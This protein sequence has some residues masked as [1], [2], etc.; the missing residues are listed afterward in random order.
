MP[1]MYFP[2]Y[3]KARDG[4][5]LFDGTILEHAHRLGVEIPSECGGLGRCGHCVVRIE[6]GADTLNPKTDLEEGHPLEPEERLACQARVVKPSGNVTVFA[7]EVGKYS[8]VT[9][10]VKTDEVS[11]D[12][13]V[14]RD[15]KHIVHDAGEVLAGY[16]G[17]I[18]GLAVDVGTT[19]LVI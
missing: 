3:R 11:L 1:K 8:I 5:D 7:K 12:P 9:E 17:E 6:R 16:R 18:Y 10:T 15:G 13:F 4:V 14:R 19:T 2:Q